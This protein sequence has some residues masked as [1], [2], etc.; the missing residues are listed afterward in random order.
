[1]TPAVLPIRER[2]RGVPSSSCTAW[3]LRSEQVQTGAVLLVQGLQVT[4]HQA[5]LR[6]EMDSPGR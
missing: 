6:Q 4:A 2:G 3:E 1:M 5:A